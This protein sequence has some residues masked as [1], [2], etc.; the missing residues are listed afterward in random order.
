M[1]ERDGQSDWRRSVDAIFSRMRKAL[2][3]GKGIRLSHAELELLNTT[4]VGEVM[5]QYQE[6]PKA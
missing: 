1:D 6:L 4:L 2:V 3:E 5:A